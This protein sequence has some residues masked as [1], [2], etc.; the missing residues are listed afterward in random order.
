MKPTLAFLHAL[1]VATIA[2]AALLVTGAATAQ[3]YPSAP[4]KII[5]PAPAG[6]GTDFLAR[7][8]G[9]RLSERMGKPVIVENKPGATG[10][11]G[12]EM[13][14]R[15]PADGYTL[16]MSYQG[17]HAINP[18]LVRNMPF[19][20]VNDFQPI[21]QVVSQPFVL[22]VNPSV[23]ATTMKD[24]VALARSKP[25]SLSFGSAG[26]GSGGHLVGEMFNMQQ[27]IKTTHIPYQGSSPMTSDLLGGHLQFAFDTVSTTGPHILSGKLRALA[28]TSDQ[29]L[30]A[31][32]QVPTAA[33]AGF[34]AMTPRGW[35]GLFAPKNTPMDIVNKLHSEI[36][37]ISK[38]PAVR[39]SLIKAGYTPTTSE[40]PEGYRAFVKAEIDRWGKVVKSSGARVD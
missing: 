40:S 21:S 17:T 1:S 28:V 3:A 30:A 13:V 31:L 12:S 33:E 7:L 5:A 35:Y 25:N 15:A 18:S 11:I 22:V 24:L 37:A 39:E 32:P 27:G 4:I 14:M 29:R 8:F 36:V 26:L 38:E 2:G 6:G 23:P 34:P 10:N 16:L 20:A 9:K 19:D